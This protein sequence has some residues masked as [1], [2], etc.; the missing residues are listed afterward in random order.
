MIT[1]GKEKEVMYHQF[2]ID[3]EDE[4]HALLLDY[5]KKHILDDED[6]LINYAIVRILKES[7]CLFIM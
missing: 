6:A 1:F 2:E 4:T 3:I 5:A 7:I